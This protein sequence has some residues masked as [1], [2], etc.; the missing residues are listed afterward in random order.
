MR[1]QFQPRLLEDFQDRTVSDS[2]EFMQ[3]KYE[4][5]S[6]ASFERCK[7]GMFLSQVGLGVWT[8][9]MCLQCTGL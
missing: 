9:T 2:S 3:E 4:N 6:V 7:K 8:L 1:T 5:Q